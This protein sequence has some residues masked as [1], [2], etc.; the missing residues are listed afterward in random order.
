MTQRPVTTRTQNT[1]VR[2]AGAGELSLLISV[3][4]AS[5]FTPATTRHDLPADDLVTATIMPG[6]HCTFQD[7]W[8]VEKFKYWLKPVKG[9]KFKGFC[10][11]CNKKFNLS[12][13]GITAVKSHSRGE[14]H[15]KKLVSK[16][17]VCSV[18]DFLPK[19]KAKSPQMQ[20]QPGVSGQIQPQP[21]VSHFEEDTSQTHCNGTCDC[22]KKLFLM[23]TEKAETTVMDNYISKDEALR[24]EILWLLKC[25]DCN[26]SFHSNM[27]VTELFCRMFK[28]SVLAERLTIGETK[29]MYIA[30]FGLAP[31]FQ[32]VL[33]NMMKDNMY[34]V[35]FDESPNR[36]LQKTMT[37]G[38]GFGMV[39]VL[40]RG[41]LHLIS[42]VMLLL[43]LLSRV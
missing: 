12:S 31:Y 5:D 19:P 16:A 32:T 10:C 1:C 23:E 4:S 39:G 20:L 24:S 36:E 26:F 40:C 37:S 21:G 18:N 3:Y 7:K 29:S 8:M 34:V 14:K 9:D 43:T 11:I 42:W 41:I 2:T 15:I 28:D 22:C 17:N 6:G 38:Y 35:M 27:H 25:V 33:E 30:V 13:M